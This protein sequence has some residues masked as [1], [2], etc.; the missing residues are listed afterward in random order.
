[1]GATV[2]SDGISG[3]AS[4]RAT[5]ASP[6][7]AEPGCS[8]SAQMSAVVL[9][10]DELEIERALRPVAVLNLETH[11]WEDNPTVL[12]VQPVGIGHRPMRGTVGLSIR[13]CLMQCP[14][15][16]SP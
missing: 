11:I 12:D 2:R 13:P 8:L 3:R 1:M 15:R 14:E 7:H 16:V 9:L 5:R 6:E 10:R 4:T